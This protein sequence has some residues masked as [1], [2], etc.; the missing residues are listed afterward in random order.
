M[1]DCL[2]VWLYDEIDWLGRVGD[3]EVRDS[4]TVQWIR[5]FEDAV[6]F[7]ISSSATGQV[8]GGYIKFRTR[9]LPVTPRKENGKTGGPPE[10]F[11]DHSDFASVPFSQDVPLAT[12]LDSV[13]PGETLFIASV[14]STISDDLPERRSFAALILKNIRPAEVQAYTDA[15]AAQQGSASKDLASTTGGKPL[16]RR[17]DISV[18]DSFRDKIERGFKLL[19]LCLRYEEATVIIV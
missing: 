16:Y 2:I 7:P 1:E 15:R 5:R 12:E 11:L 6:T 8:D 19:E 17:W 13:V 10:F 14:I 4:R 3:N 18:F 9:M